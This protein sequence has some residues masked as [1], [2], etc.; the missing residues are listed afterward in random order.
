MLTRSPNQNTPEF[1]DTHAY[2]RSIHKPMHAGAWA[3]IQIAPEFQP[4]RKLASGGNTSKPHPLIII[5][6]SHN[7]QLLNCFDYA[8]FK[9]I[10]DDHTPTNEQS[11]HST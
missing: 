1:V 8:D 5:E 4:E 11:F 2:E 3:G 10:T 9:N 7:H 6:P